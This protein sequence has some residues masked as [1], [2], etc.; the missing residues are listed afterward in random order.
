MTDKDDVY[1]KLGQFGLTEHDAKVYVY[2]LERGEGVA[3]GKIAIA[4]G[5][6][7]QYVY[8]SL[9]KLK[10]LVLIEEIVLGARYKYQALPLYQ[11]EKLAKEYTEKSQK[12]VQELA[13]LSTV[14]VEQ[15]IEYYLGERAVHDFEIRFVDNV[16]MDESQYVIGGSSK[17]FLEFFG[18]E[19][20]GLVKILKKKKV[21]TYYI[22]GPNEHEELEKAHIINNLFEYRIVDTFPETI[23]STTIRFDT[24]TIYSL[25]TP[26]LVYVIKSKIVSE[27]YKKYFDMLWGMGK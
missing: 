27:N 18:D 20:D 11:M 22:G 12:L 16:K 7:R 1:A 24:V 6:H 8:N 19:Y 13:T 17:R 23:T 21:K 15:D 9:D 5:M 14:K 26:P 3:A 10:K 4:N 25:A 2:L